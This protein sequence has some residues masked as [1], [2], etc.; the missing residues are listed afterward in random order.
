MK[1]TDTCYYMSITKEEN[2]AFVVANQGLGTEPNQVV[3]ETKGDG[4][5]SNADA[6]TS[7]MGA[8]ITTTTSIG[9]NATTPSGAVGGNNTVNGTSELPDYRVDD[10]YINN[11]NAGT[12]LGPLESCN[13]YDAPNPRA[14]SALPQV[15][16]QVLPSTN[17]PPLQHNLLYT[18]DVCRECRMRK[19]F[20]LYFS[21]FFYFYL[22][23][24]R[25]LNILF[26][27]FF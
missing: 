8:T 12:C 18:S 27:N 9:T 11:N 3:V 23:N 2:S 19:S 26:L 22:F 6:A 4:Q 24:F 1:K 21:L 13:D 20:F 5:T 16:L 14:Q 17:S 25:F 7:H 15:I 10:Y